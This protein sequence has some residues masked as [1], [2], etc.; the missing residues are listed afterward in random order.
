MRLDMHQ[1]LEMTP[2]R[3]N[4][5]FMEQIDMSV[6]FFVLCNVPVAMLLRLPSGSKRGGSG[7]WQDC[8][9]TLGFGKQHF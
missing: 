1:F 2:R 8:P 6:D 7:G 4:V 5:F 9:K 3:M